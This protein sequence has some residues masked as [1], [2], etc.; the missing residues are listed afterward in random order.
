MSR[1]NNKIEFVIAILNPE[2]CISDSRKN[3]LNVTQADIR[4]TWESAINPRMA[5][6]L[7]DSVYEHRAAIV[8]RICGI[9]VSRAKAITTTVGAVGANWIL[10]IPMARI[11]GCSPTLVPNGVKRFPIFGRHA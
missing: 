5:A 2:S 11:L 10:S 1:N 6:S 9:V 8:A 3:S 4:D 7:Y